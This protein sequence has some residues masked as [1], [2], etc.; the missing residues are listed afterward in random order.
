MTTVDDSHKKKNTHGQHTA[1][2]Y[3]DDYDGTRYKRLKLFFVLYIF[4][5]E[6]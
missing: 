3:D 1:L 4:V 2:N 5:V 6:T